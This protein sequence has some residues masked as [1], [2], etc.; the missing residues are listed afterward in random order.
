[1]RKFTFALLM[2]AL[3]IATVAS[4]Q[5][6]PAPDLPRADGSLV[7]S[8]PINGRGETAF[9]YVP[10]DPV[11]YGTEFGLCLAWDNGGQHFCL[12]NLRLEEDR[13]QPIE[14]GAANFSKL[15]IQG[16]VRLTLFVQT[17]ENGEQAS[18]VLYTD[19]S[20]YPRPYQ[21]QPVT[22]TA[23]WNGGREQVTFV[24]MKLSATVGK[25]SAAIGLRAAEVEAIDG[26]FRVVLDPKKF[27]DLGSG[28]YSVT[29]CDG[30]GYCHNSAV[31]LAPT[32]NAQ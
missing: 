2:L 23:A 18:R 30:G 27:A 24:G 26:G 17:F 12:R 7:L 29:V 15:R 19:V 16:S 21:S 3:A 8:P 9:W 32:T 25:L 13:T 4:G 22:A 6:L 14:L 1:M 28:I 11:S 10:S 31:N 20:M 5:Q